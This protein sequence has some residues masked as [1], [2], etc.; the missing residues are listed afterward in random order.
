MRA[1]ILTQNQK[2]HLHK[3][4]TQTQLHLERH[5]FTHSSTEIKLKKKGQQEA[6]KRLNEVK[7]KC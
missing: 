7:S 2:K 3:N 1:K 5:P 6:Q 4:H